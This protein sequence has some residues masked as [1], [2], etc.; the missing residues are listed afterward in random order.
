MSG[1]RL[2]PRLAL[3]LLPLLLWDTW[4]LL[5][6]RFG[7]HLSAVPLALVG[8]AVAAPAFRRLSAG[9]GPPVPLAPL[10]AAL[11]LYALATAVAPPLLAA[12]I[13]AVTIAL[14]CRFVAGSALPAAPL[15]GLVLLALPLLP[16]LE[17]YLA[18]PMRLA[19]AALAAALLRLNGIAVA[20]EGVALSWNGSL[21]LFD[22]ACSGI[23]MLWAALFLA[24]GIA[25][26]AG[27]GVRRYLRALAIA[28]AMA[29]AANSVRAASLF[30]LENGFVERLRGPIAHE[31]VGL[32]AFLLFA[33]AA[34]AMIAPRS[35]RR[36]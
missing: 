10:T 23:R 22:A 29:I 3:A 35:W 27:F 7:D 8:L 12:G 21:L 2:D 5:A 36:G 11:L 15:A 13:A 4:R 24:S 33:I 6:G 1:A 9:E 18:Y 19:G 30:Y 31:A 26:A 32:A 28:L 25:L 17:F 14:L 34:I 20:A 16:T